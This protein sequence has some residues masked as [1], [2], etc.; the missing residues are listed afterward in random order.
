MF[1]RGTES[2]PYNPRSFRR[3]V[4]MFIH[5]LF[6]PVAVKLGPVAVR[7]Y[8]VRYLA[9]FVVG[10]L[11]GRHRIRTRPDMGWTLKDMDDLLFYAVLGVVLG[12]RLGYVLFYK[13]S[14][15]LADPVRI[16]YVW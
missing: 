11:L 4:R 6:D 15:Y 1:A 16:F 2:G 12:G 5:P 9:A 13:L 14:D 8:G 7:W 3:R 10:L